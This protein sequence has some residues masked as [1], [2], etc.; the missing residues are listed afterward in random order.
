MMPV[1]AL[2]IIGVITGSIVQIL[3][4][5]YKGDVAGQLLKGSKL[6]FHLQPLSFFYFNCSLNS[7]S[8]YISFHGVRVTY[9]SQC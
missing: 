9:F 1:N 4:Q 5:G 2:F 6:I 8:L 3:E 7:P